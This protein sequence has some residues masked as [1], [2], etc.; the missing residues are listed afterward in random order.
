MI[1]GK[2]SDRV[3]VE[4]EIDEAEMALEII[5]RGI[6][7]L[8]KEDPQARYGALLHHSIFNILGWIKGDQKE[9]EQEAKE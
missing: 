3:Y 1:A 6:K 4:F 2:H 5:M 9:K 7:N 8:D